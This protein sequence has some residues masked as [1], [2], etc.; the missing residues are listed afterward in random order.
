MIIAVS[1]TEHETLFFSLLCQL[2]YR[3]EVGKGGFEPPNQKFPKEVAVSDTYMT[4]FF[5]TF[6]FSIFT[7]SPNIKLKSTILRPQEPLRMGYAV[8][9]LA[10]IS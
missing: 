3:L 10:R 2:S 7:T 8:Y 9:L 5:L 6:A 4:H 1:F